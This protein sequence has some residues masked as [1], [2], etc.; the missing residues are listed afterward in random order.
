VNLIANEESD[1]PKE[2]PST[3]TTVD[4]VDSNVIEVFVTKLV[5]SAD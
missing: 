5:T 3:V 2:V 1:G 4:P